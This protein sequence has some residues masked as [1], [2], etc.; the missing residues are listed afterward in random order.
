MKVFKAIIKI[1]VED[2]DDVK[3]MKL[4]LRYCVLIL[5]LFC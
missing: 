3:I 1:V 4:Y 5:F 2:I